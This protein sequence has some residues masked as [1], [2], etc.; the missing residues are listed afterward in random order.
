MLCTMIPLPKLNIGML[1]SS[2]EDADFWFAGGLEGRNCK[3]PP[4]A[5]GHLPPPNTTD[6]QLIE[7]KQGF[8]FESEL[9]SGI[10]C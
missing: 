2:G 9:G 7:H 6:D 5:S 10:C 8:N 4:P 3:I 1:S